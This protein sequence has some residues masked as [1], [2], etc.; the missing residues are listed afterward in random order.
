[1]RDGVIKPATAYVPIGEHPI[2]WFSTA[3]V[4]EET[5]NKR[6][7]KPDG[8]VVNLDRDGTYAR[9]G[10][11][12]RIGVAPETAPYTWGILKVKSRMK[13]K[14]AEG[15]VKAARRCGAKP[16]EWRG[17]FDPVPREKWIA[18]EVWDGT[19]WVSIELNA[20]NADGERNQSH[21]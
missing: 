6:L 15:L 16:S 10:G 7:L 17:T 8:T 18:V 20:P 5:A 21:A 19:K 4:W 2:V 14:M 13:P 9:G 12:V 3:P 1:V 11:L